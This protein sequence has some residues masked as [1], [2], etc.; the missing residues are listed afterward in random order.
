[1]ADY[2]SAEIHSGD[3]LQRLALREMGDASHWVSIALLNGLRPPYIV[4]DPFLAADGVAVAGDR[5]LLPV[6]YVDSQVVSDDALLTD[7]L[8][9]DGLLSV[10]DSGGLAL[11][12]GVENF[13]QSVRIRIGVVKRDL[14]FHP[15]FGC[16]VS[17]LLGQSIG[18][19]ANR[20]AAFYVRSALLEDAR[21]SS[22]SAVATVV[23]DQIRV[24]AIVAP[25]SGQP[26]TIEVVV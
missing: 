17:R 9:D 19:T 23:G 25:V 7:A 4:D 22:A 11:V 14:W 15:D 21:V 6:A 16:L 2:R 5:I 10:D 26:Q 18:H 20:L 8:L 24:V 13:I 3:S 12:S 1:V